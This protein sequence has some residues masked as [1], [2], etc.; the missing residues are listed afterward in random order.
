MRC[1]LSF[2]SRSKTFFFLPHIHIHRAYAQLMSRKIKWLWI[3]NKPY[4]SPNLIESY[5]VHLIRI[6]EFK[7]ANTQ[8][9]SSL[10]NLSLAARNRLRFHPGPPNVREAD[11][12][13]E[14]LESP[15]N[16]PRERLS[17]GRSAVLP[18]SATTQELQPGLISCQIFLVL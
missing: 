3:K 7:P 11:G 9:L 10:Q 18:G 8:N 4:C 16:L 17:Q 5:L 14:P 12:S 2:P 1:V 13:E 6:F 15:L